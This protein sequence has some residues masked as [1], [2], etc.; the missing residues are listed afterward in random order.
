MLKNKQVA[1]YSIL[2]YVLAI[3]GYIIIDTNPTDGLGMLL[4]YGGLLVWVVLGI[5]GWVR[6]IKSND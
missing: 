4:A 6:L 2:G 5:Y 3:I 1:W